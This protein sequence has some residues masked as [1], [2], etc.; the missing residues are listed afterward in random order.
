MFTSSVRI[1]FFFKVISWTVAWLLMSDGLVWV[2]QKLLMFGYFCNMQQYSNIRI[3]TQSCVKNQNTS[4]KWHFCVQ[5]HFVDWMRQLRTGW[6]DWFKLTG[7][8]LLLFTNVLNK[9]ASWNT[10]HIKFWDRLTT[11]AAGHIAFYSC[12]SRTSQKSEA[13]VSTSSLK[14][15]E[16]TGGVSGLSNCATNKMRYKKW[17]IQDGQSPLEMC[18]LPLLTHQL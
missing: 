11:T 2:F 15:E 13:V 12:Q 7:R 14:T 8:I 18:A 9:T 5:K 6:P 4:R 3:S 10:Q 17:P 16:R 1:F